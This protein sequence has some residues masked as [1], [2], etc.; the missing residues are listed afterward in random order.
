M[1]TILTFLL[2]TC[3]SIQVNATDQEQLHLAIDNISKTL[4]ASMVA[5]TYCSGSQDKVTVAIAKDILERSSILFIFF[6]ND[7]RV[8]QSVKDE[9]TRRVKLYSEQYINELSE[10]KETRRIVCEDKTFNILDNRLND[11]SSVFMLKA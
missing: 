5:G 4:S 11:L 1:K 9:V 3:F 7:E 8:D 2:L 6:L 10:S